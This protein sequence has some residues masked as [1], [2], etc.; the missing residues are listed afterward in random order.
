MK[1][2]EGLELNGIK[3]NKK[4][5]ESLSKQERLNLIDPIFNLLRINGWIYPDDSSKIKNDWKRLLNYIPDLNNPELFNN[6]SLATSICKYFC[7]SF[8]SATEENK[9][10]MIEIFNNDS[11]LKKIIQN[12]LGLD[13]LDTDEKG[14]GVNEAFNLSFKMIIQG[15]RSM[16]L[17]PA[18]S[19]FKPE[20]A[21]YI[22]MKY[23]NEGDTV[24][25]Y[26]CGFGGRLLGAMSCGRKYIGTDPLTTPELQTMIIFFKFKDCTLINKGSEDYFG[27]ENSVDLYWSSPPYYDQEYYSSDS[28][29]AYNKGE[30]YFYNV[31]WKSTLH[32]VKHMLKPNKWFG[33]NVKNYPKML[34]MAIETFGPIQ[35][36]INLKTIRNHLTKSAGISKMEGVYMFKN[37]K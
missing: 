19:M 11:M 15:M 1:Y 26:S 34:D 29:Q 16:R 3:L 36:T 17:V 23:S 32:S 37:N 5:I 8:Y 9:P 27:K 4:Y 12:R 6:S 24:G 33:L 30:D 2:D 7:N 28:T 22:C 21:K 31:Y 13:W 14:P 20:I 25:D 18:I 35:E 10:T